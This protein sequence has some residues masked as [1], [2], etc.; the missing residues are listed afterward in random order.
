MNYPV[1]TAQQLRAVLRGLRQMRG[2]SQE[3]VGRLL[4]VN[5][6]RAA[7]IES[8]PG[9]TGFDQ[10]ARLVAGLGGRLVIETQEAASAGGSTATA[11][12]KKNTKRKASVRKAKADQG[13]W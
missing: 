2:L 9:V 1:A 5:Q 11:S 7:R 12:P 3:Q 6:K 4:G 8:A 10:I 13:S